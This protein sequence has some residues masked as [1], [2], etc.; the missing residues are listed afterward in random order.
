MTGE[1][2]FSWKEFGNKKIQYMINLAVNLVVSFVMNGFKFKFNKPSSKLSGKEILKTMGK[3]IAIR[4]GKNI[5]KRVMN[6]YIIKW[7]KEIIKKLK[8]IFN[9]KIKEFINKLIIPDIKKYLGNMILIDQISNNKRWI[10]DFFN[11]IEIFV[12]SFQN[13]ISSIALF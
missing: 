11:K 3:E 7:I 1:K 6:S 10:N 12:N 2:Q 5:G 8:D 9:Q 13:L 4:A